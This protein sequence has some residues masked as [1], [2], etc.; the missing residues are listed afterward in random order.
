MIT[1]NVRLNVFLLIFF[2]I[3]YIQ[4]LTLSG[5]RM[6]TNHRHLDHAELNAVKPQQHNTHSSFPDLVHKVVRSCFFL[7]FSEHAVCTSPQPQLIEFILKNTTYNDKKRRFYIFVRRG[8][9]LTKTITCGTATLRSATLCL[10]LND[11][12]KNYKFMSF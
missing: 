6:N 8:N 10:S 7:F 5:V 3:Q 4:L 11:G 9:E 2:F 1:F 12:H